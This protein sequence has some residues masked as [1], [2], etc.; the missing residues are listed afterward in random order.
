ML[1]AWRSGQTPL[2]ESITASDGIKYSHFAASKAVIDGTFEP[3]KTDLD[4]VMDKFTRPRTYTWTL[5]LKGI[6]AL[7]ELTND[8]LYVF[9]HGV[10]GL[11]DLR[12][13]LLSGKLSMDDYE[14]LTSINTA[15]VTLYDAVTEL[16]NWTEIST[17]RLAGHSWG[18]G[19][20]PV[21]GLYIYANTGLRPTVQLINPMQVM[22]QE[23]ADFIADCFPVE[24]YI[25]RND[26]LDWINK[27]RSGL[28]YV[29]DV[30]HSPERTKAFWTAW[31]DHNRSVLWGD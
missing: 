3:D 15:T 5:N 16:I 29:G 17:V 19:I 6:E 20:A 26:W 23:L 13:I 22:N 21:L 24:T 12:H 8:S 4:K 25:Y 18:G 1:E 31:G 7:V 30:Y 27:R 9:V 28:V 14:V 2:H 10:N 11:S